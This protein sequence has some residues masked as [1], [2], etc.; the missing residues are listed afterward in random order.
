MDSSESRLRVGVVG[1][2]RVG[3]A[4]GAAL[5]R[6]G[7]K[8]VAAS[9]VS[10]ES[11]RRAEEMLP[12]V[13][14]VS[15][16]DVFA[17]AEL[18]LLTVPDDALPSLVS[19]LVATESIRPGTL[20]V[21][22]S[23]RYGASVLEE[24]TRI[25]GLP[26]ALHPAM[27]FTG[28][29]VDV[30][31]LD[32]CSFGVTTLEPLRPIAEALVVEMGGEPEWITE[33]ARPLYHAALA[34]GSNYIVTLVAQAAELLAEAGVAHPGRMLG[35]L[36]GASL[37][38]ALRAGDAALTGP[39]ARGDAGTVKAHLKVLE[40]RGGLNASAATGYRALGRLTADRALASGL[41]K[42]EKAEQ[43]LDALKEEGAGA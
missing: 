6:V 26:L 31:R 2:G 24:A 35:P 11:V 39:V 1:T 27:T 23:G 30:A 13:P 25:G 21:H 38:N 33:E 18:V 37:D 4:L 5:D 12:G 41:L 9:G 20:L 28:T 19:G 42:A 22:T 36:L 17:S 29:D 16:Q 7:H 14:L 15:V 8:V 3:S 10:L 40:G 32:G 43:L 34:Y